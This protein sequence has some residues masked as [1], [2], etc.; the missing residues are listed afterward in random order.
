MKL[1][2]VALVAASCICSVAALGVKPVLLPCTA[3]C[4][5]KATKSLGLC[6]QDMACYC[7]PKNFVPIMNAARECIANECDPQFFGAWMKLANEAFCRK[8]IA[9][10][11]ADAR[12]PAG[13]ASATPSVQTTAHTPATTLAT[14]T[15]IEVA[16][17]TPAPTTST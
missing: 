10:I 5:R 13:R 9:S 2:T 8:L 6:V 3:M 12:T 15:S 16:A 14:T 4:V 7:I 17:D 11:E 1:A